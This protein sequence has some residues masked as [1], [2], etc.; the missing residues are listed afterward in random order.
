VKPVLSLVVGKSGPKLV[1]SAEKP[2]PIDETVPLKPGESRLVTEDGPV[3]VIRGSD[4]TTTYNMGVKGLMISRIDQGT[5]TLHLNGKAITMGGF[6][7]I[8]TRFSQM[9]DNGGRPFVDM[10]GLQGHYEI[11]FDLSTADMASI[12]RAR[13]I[14]IPEAPASSEPGGQ[15]LLGAVESLGIKLESRKAM[16]GEVIIDHVEKTPTA[17]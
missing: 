5:Q 17:N 14:D 8:L 4:G 2:G 3:H 9:L 12:A 10:T 6:A 7:D 1:E 16:V 15:S 11:A 13:G